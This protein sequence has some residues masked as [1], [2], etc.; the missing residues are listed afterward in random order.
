MDGGEQIGA[1]LRTR[2]GV[3]PIFVSVGHRVSLPSAVKMVLAC[4]DGYRIPK[5]QREADHWVKELKRL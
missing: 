5:P 2:D 1:A 3:S 4:T